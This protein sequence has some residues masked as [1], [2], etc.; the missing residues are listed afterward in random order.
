MKRD[1]SNFVTKCMV[2]KK[3]KAEHQ[4][5]SGLLHPIKIPEWKCDRII[6]DFVVGLLMSAKLIYVLNSF[7]MLFCAFYN[8]IH[9][10]LIKFPLNLVL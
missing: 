6:M 3:M 4:V 2:Y 9:V 7:H 8:H 1:V 10:K 5:S